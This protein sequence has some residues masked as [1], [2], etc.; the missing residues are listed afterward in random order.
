MLELGLER[1]GDPP[2]PW[3]WLALGGAA[4]QEQALG[5]DQDHALA[6]AP[7]DEP[8]EQVDPFFAELAT[9]VTDG[10]ADAGIP[11][12]EGNAMATNPLLRVSL[13]GWERRLAGWMEDFSVMGSV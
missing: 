10:L 1:L 2:A 3:A 12:C 4:R 8:D 9:F 6:Y 13:G 7:G 5:T 11:R